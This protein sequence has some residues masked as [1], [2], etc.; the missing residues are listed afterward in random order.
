MK[1][2]TIILFSILLNSCGA[3]QDS[4][5]NLNPDMDKATQTLNGD[6][7]V[8]LLDNQSITSQ[9]I[10]L[11]FDDANKRVSGFSGCN[12][13]F[14]TYNLDNESLTFSNLASTK[15]FC[16]EEANAL[17]QNYLKALEKTT[18]FKVANNTI[19]LLNN[20]TVVLNATPVI[21]T[22]G[23]KQD[24]SLSFKYTAFA[25]GSYTMI[26]IDQT[27]VTSQFSRSEKEN[28]KACSTQDW[29]TITTLSKAIDIKSLNT[30]EPPSTAHQYDGAASSNLTI[31]LNGEQYSTPTFDAGN[32]PKEIAALITKIWEIAKPETKN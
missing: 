15:K 22:S 14:G 7:K 20:D 6:Y 8:T 23:Q 19:S 30:L 11:T 24:Q 25:R 16:Q 21:V 29:D 32:P 13:F 26:N 27:T 4:K 3:T 9:E 1:T 12:N 31:T 18:N 17:E 10:T 5:S 28:T 2:I